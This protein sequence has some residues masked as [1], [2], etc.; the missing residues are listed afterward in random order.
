T[1][2]VVDTVVGAWWQARRWCP[3]C[4]RETEQHRHRCG[5]TTVHYRGVSWLGNDAVNLLCTVAGA[6]AMG[7]ILRIAIS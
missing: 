5:T 4:E 2:A 3:S 6:A 7:A 1:G